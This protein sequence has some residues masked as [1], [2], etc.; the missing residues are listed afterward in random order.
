MNIRSLEAFVAVCETRSFTEAAKRLHT[1]QPA[2]SQMI[3]EVEKTVG[4][5]LFERLSRRVYVTRAGEAFRGRAEAMLAMW[6]SLYD[7]PANAERH[8]LLRIG[9]C[10][11]IAGY[12]LPGILTR[13]ARQAPEIRY[14]ITVG[15][16]ASVLHQVENNE[17]DIG[18]YEGPSPSGPYRCEPFSSYRL[19]PVCSPK[20]AFAKKRKVT[21][22]ALLGE[23]LLLREH[24]SAVRDVFDSFLRLR[25]IE[26]TPVVTSVNSQALIKLVEQ[27]IGV[28][29]LP[30]PVIEHTV[31]A[32]TIAAFSV[33]GMEL[34]NTNH[35]VHHQDKQ[36]TPAL[37]TF[38]Q[39]VRSGPDPRQIRRQA[40]R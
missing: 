31:R 38:M 21:V 2:I 1:T 28:S 3:R 18:L 35:L 13:L 24:G 29:L 9:C 22:E 8:P 34:G 40:K 30:E 11:T 26:A 25:Q 36:I 4:M 14:E 37:D 39:V 12:W 16:A 33:Q 7:E 6:Q 23:K 10:L 5:P 27:N 20:H 32:R 19:I 15:V 17:V